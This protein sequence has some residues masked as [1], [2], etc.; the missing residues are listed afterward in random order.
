METLEPG[1]SWVV[2]AYRRIVAIRSPKSGD[3][4]NAM[5]LITAM[6]F[7]M[8]GTIVLVV[9]ALRALDTAVVKT[10]QIDL[11]GVDHT[12][13]ELDSSLAVMRAASRSFVEE[14]PGRSCST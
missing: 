9:V 5:T 14:H 4:C 3:R 13:G 1:L 7:L 10:E 6:F 8:A 2:V 11:G 12:V